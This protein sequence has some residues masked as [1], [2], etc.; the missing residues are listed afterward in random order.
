MEYV[1]TDNE[2][3]GFAPGEMVLDR[4]PTRMGFASVLEIVSSVRDASP[5]FGAIRDGL[6]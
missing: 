6:Q 2:A 3:V 5:P 4:G 1:F